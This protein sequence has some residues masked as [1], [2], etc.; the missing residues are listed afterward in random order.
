MTHDIK[1]RKYGKYKFK[2]KNVSFICLGQSDMNLAS[3]AYFGFMIIKVTL[4][5]TIRN[6]DF[7][8]NNDVIL[9]STS[10]L[11]AFFPVRGVVFRIFPIISTSSL[12]QGNCDRGMGT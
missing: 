10:P 9:F 12:A 8:R 5:K 4:H 3:V 2:K 1:S 11:V 7:L 6:N